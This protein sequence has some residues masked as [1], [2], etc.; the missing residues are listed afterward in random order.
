MDTKPLI[1]LI[2]VCYNAELLLEATLN[3][4]IN[5]TYKNIELVIIDG[6]SSDQTV[7]IAKKFEQ[8]IGTLISEPDKGIYDAMNKGILASKGEWIYFLN[9]GDLFF[10]A[11]ILEEL[12]SNNNSLL[13]IDFIYGKM[14]TINEPTGV[15]YVAGEQVLFQSFYFKY[16][17]CHQ[18]TFTRK[19]AFNYMPMLSTAYKIMS[20]NHWQ[21]QFFKHYSNKA[22]FVNLIIAFYDIQ[23]AS[24][25]KRMLGY[26]EF[27]SYAGKWLPVWVYLANL[28]LYPYIWFK[29]KFIRIFQET[30]W[31]KAYRKLKFK[32]QMANV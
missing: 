9:A 27:L 1:S 5:Q 10:H 20:D 18:T 17:I 22:L 6:G 12:F 29:V 13:G 31:F 21:M 7:S 11:R 19:S 3:S 30:S 24:Y 4:A 23:G 26:R 28:I 15:N 8:Y 2:T 32:D 16:P 25:H 14:Q